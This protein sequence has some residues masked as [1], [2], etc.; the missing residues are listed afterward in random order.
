MGSDSFT[1]PSLSFPTCEME[2][3][4]APFLRGIEKFS[5]FLLQMGT[6]QQSSSL[7]L[8]GSGGRLP[9]RVPRGRWQERSVLWL[10]LSQRWKQ[11]ARSPGVVC[12]SI[13]PLHSRMTGQGP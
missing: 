13:A 10:S 4:T 7:F 3:L 9:L 2:T 11:A 6:C 5:R 1:C 12:A 8:R